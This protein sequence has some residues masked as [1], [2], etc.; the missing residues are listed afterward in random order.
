MGEISNKLFSVDPL[1]EYNIG[2]SEG[3]H[4]LFTYYIENEL[5]TCAKNLEENLKQN[6]A[7]F[8]EQ[9]KKD[10]K[11]PLKDI[12]TTSPDDLSYLYDRIVYLYKSAASEKDDQKFVDD[13]MRVEINRIVI[14]FYDRH[15]LYAF[16]DDN[17]PYLKFLRDY[18]QKIKE[19]RKI[20]YDFLQTTKTALHNFL[21][22]YIAIDNS[23][24]VN[25]ILYRSQDYLETIY[26]SQFIKD[27]ENEIKTQYKEV[28]DCLESAKTY[29]GK[30]DLD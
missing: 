16:L 14:D 28:T 17:N 20:S 7:M 12:K 23:G 29:S 11:E 8:E 6:Y 24:L 22:S 3:L 15:G 18:Y 4:S 9:L 25:K 13:K 19:I 5:K 26:Y 21:N 10:L 30:K 27:K 2:T 1:P